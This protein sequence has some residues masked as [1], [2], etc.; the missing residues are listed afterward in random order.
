VVSVWPDFLA[1]SRIVDEDLSTVII[2]SRSNAAVVDLSGMLEG[3]S[4]KLGSSNWPSRSLSVMTFVSTVANR[5]V[6]TVRST[7]TLALEV[8]LSRKSDNDYNHVGDFYRFY[9]NIF[10]VLWIVRHISL[11]RRISYFLNS[12]LES[13]IKGIGE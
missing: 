11:A 9:E 13:A 7:V 4:I 8:E 2:F 10:R 6:P 3:I 1:A 5:H 12:Y